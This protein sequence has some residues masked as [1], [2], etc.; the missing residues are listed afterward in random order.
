LPFEFENEY[1][2]TY[3]FALYKK[4]Y[5][6]KILNDF[7]ISSKVAEVKEKFLNFTNDL[8]IHEIT[9]N[10]NGILI[11]KEISKNLELDNIY[12]KAKRQYDLVYKDFKIRKN[13]AVNK[14]VLAL[15]IISLTINIINFIAIFK[16]K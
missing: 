16:L 3:I 14:L 2:Y 12:E 4:F 15:L 9:N 5:L 1:F 10:D 11:Y 6:C 13:E 8:W 7:K